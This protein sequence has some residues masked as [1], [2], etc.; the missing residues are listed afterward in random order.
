MK[1]L[2]FNIYVKKMSVSLEKKCRNVFW[3]NITIYEI[4]KINLQLYPNTETFFWFSEI[5]RRNTNDKP[6]KTIRFQNFW[7]SLWKKNVLSLTT[8]GKHID[9][10]F[11][12]LIVSDWV[13]PYAFWRSKNVWKIMSI[14][15]K[16][17]FANVSSR[18]ISTIL[19]SVWTAY[20]HLISIV[21]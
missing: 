10:N 3:Y 11:R 13:I 7:K 8:F 4:A 1:V 6:W 2:F 20:I 16:W 21:G 14:M 15:L 5:I 19:H 17:I 12:K 9:V 18:N